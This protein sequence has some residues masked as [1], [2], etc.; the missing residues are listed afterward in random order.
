MGTVRVMGYARW[1]EEQ[2][3]LRPIRHAWRVEVA[4]GRPGRA[5]RLATSFE[6]TTSATGWLQ[7]AGTA[8]TLRHPSALG[9]RPRPV[10]AAAWTPPAP[11]AHSGMEVRS[12]G[13]PPAPNRDPEGVATGAGGDT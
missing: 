13:R 7:V 1:D 9:G 3:V 8:T 4:H 6:N 10:P 2:P 11:H 5:H 12:G